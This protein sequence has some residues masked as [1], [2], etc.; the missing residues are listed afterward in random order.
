MY[1]YGVTYILCYYAL[2]KVIV[3]LKISMVVLKI[4][5]FVFIKQKPVYYTN[6]GF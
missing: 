4:K 2:R 6:V 5:S 3:K 1:V